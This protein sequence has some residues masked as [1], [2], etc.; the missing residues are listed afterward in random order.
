MTFR[1]LLALGLAG[2][3]TVGSDASAG[4]CTKKSGTVVFREACGKKETA[5]G[6]DALGL[7]TG[8]GAGP[9]GDK[10][11]R[12]PKGE[13]GE[14]GPKGDQ[15]DTGD[16]G[17]STIPTG[18]FTYQIP[19][20]YIGDVPAPGGQDGRA[21]ASMVLPAGRYLVMAK[22]DAVNFGTPVLVR[23]FL[24]IGTYRAL[25]ATAFIGFSPNDN[26]GLVETLTLMLPVDVGAGGAVTVR[27]RPDTNPGGREK[28]YL[29]QGIMIAVPASGFALR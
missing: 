20:A 14:P 13:P 26:V 22:V 9:K 11:D 5:L 3:L 17:D 7:G 19:N 24:D 29:E 15:G 21:V 2:A 6:L 16:K 27:C 18:Y 10:G 23:C 1:S 28:S 12:G 4:L 25:A 8:G